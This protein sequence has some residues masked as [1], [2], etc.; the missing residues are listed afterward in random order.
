MRKI[1]KFVVS[2]FLMTALSLVVSAAKDNDTAAS[3]SVQKNMTFGQ[4]VSDAAIIKNS[5]YSTTKDTLAACKVDAKNQTDSR[6]ILKQCKADYKKDKKQCKIEF[7]S[8]KN[9]CR[10][11]KHN[12]MD[13]IKAG[14]Q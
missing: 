11:I 1:T 14:L 10:K 12:F 2:L 7:K 6:P 4:C 5:C 9:E 13:S 3:D 8:A